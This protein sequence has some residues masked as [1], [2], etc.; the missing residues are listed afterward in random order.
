MAG[1]VRLDELE[2]VKLDANGDQL[3]VKTQKEIATRLVREAEEALPKGVPADGPYARLTRD[4]LISEAHRLDMR[5]GALL[6]EDELR[7][8][9]E[10]YRIKL[11]VAGTPKPVA[12]QPPVPAYVPPPVKIRGLKPSPTNRWIVRDQREKRPPVSVGHGQMANLANGSIIELRH[13]STAILQG[14]VDQGVKLIP[15]EDDKDED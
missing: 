10:H 8:V 1:K 12:A 9:C 7:L 14:I 4:Q 3:A 15:L 5:F 13:Y 11:S 6:T 2:N